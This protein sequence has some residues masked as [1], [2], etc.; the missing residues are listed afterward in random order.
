MSI[1]RASISASSLRAERRRGGLF[2][3]RIISKADAIIA[4]NCDNSRRIRQAAIKQDSADGEAIAKKDV[5]LRT[6]SASNFTEFSQV[7]R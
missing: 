2:M 1:S 6:K 3:V 7:R 4:A 5:I